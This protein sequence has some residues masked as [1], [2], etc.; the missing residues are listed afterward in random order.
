MLDT[1]QTQIGAAITVLVVA[2]AFLKGD[3]PERIGGGAYVLAWFASLLIQDDGAGTG[4]QWGLMGVDFVLMAVYA[5][6]SWKSRRAWPVWASGLQ[7]LI[8]MSHLLTLVDIRP[9][10]MAFY[11]VMNLASY[12]ILLALAIGAFRAWHERRV[13]GL[14]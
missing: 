9:P 8:V 10:L 3:E 5:G 2:F 4:V 13:I 7:A 11:A 14:E 6:L 12:G 1:L